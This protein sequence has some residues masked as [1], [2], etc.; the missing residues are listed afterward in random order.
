MYDY[1]ATRLIK[2]R[3]SRGVADPP[4]TSLRWSREVADPSVTSHG[5]NLLKKMNPPGT[6]SSAYTDADPVNLHHP[7]FI[8]K[9]LWKKA[10]GDADE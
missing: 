9:E 3:W 2:V 7:D 8:K 10:D 4:V 1:Q 5:V 6:G